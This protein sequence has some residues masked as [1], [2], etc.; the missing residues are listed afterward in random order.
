MFVGSSI[1]FYGIGFAVGVTPGTTPDE[2]IP[3]R[4]K[5]VLSL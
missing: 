2:E 3:T 4:G 1:Q 5:V